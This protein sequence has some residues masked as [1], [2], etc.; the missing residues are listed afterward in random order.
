M[1]ERRARLHATAADVA[2]ARRPRRRLLDAAEAAGP[3]AGGRAGRSRRRPPC[4]ARPGGHPAPSWPHGRRDPAARR[5]GAAR[6]AAAL[7]AEPAT[8]PQPTA[9]RRPQPAGARRP[10]HPGSAPAQSCARRRAAAAALGVLVAGRHSRVVIA[11]LAAGRRRRA[12]PSSADRVDLVAAAPS[13][14]GTTD[15]GAARRPRPARR[16]LRAVACPVSPRTLA[17]L[18]GRHVDL[19]G[20]PGVLLVL[21]TGERGVFRRRGRRPGLRPGRWHPARRR[22]GVG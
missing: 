7:A 17:L 15:V 2:P 21:A 16:C 12:L 22:L 20:R 9:R 18:G 13:A 11:L 1:T 8:A 5:R 14:V 19:A 4:S 10:R 6:W 3:V